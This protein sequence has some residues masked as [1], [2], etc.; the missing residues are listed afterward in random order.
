MSHVTRFG[1]LEGD[2][3]NADQFGEYS[4]VTGNLSTTGKI[5]LRG[6][7]FASAVSLT[8]AQLLADY[9]SFKNLIAANVV[10]TGV[11]AFI[12][13][14]NVDELIFGAATATS[15][16]LLVPGPA[17]AASVATASES[18]VQLFLERP[19]VAIALGARS[20]VQPATVTLRRESVSRSL[21]CAPAAGGNASD[22]SPAHWEIGSQFDKIS[23]IVGGMAGN[24]VRASVGIVYL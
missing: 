4:T 9:E 7:K 1:L 13:Q 8:C 12:P 22:E 2:S 3:E 6:C 24:V 21:T 23:L 17:S 10:V 18:T 5:T 15:G 16:Q 19:W 14:F 20:L 11:A